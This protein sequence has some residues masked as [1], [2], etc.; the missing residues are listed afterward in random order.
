[1]AAPERTEG[2]PI[3]PG[4]SG[5]TRKVTWSATSSPLPVPPACGPARAGG[6]RVT[7][8]GGFCLARGAD[9]YKV[10]L[11]EDCR[12][13]AST[14][15]GEPLAAVA[16]VAM[17]SNMKCSVVLVGVAEGH[18]GVRGRSVQSL[19]LQVLRGTAGIGFA[20]GLW[21]SLR[22]PMAPQGGRG[23]GPGGA[24]GSFWHPLSRLERRSSHADRSLS[25][26]RDASWGTPEK[27]HRNQRRRADD[28][29]GDLQ[30]RPTGSG[31]PGIRAACAVPCP[32]LEGVER[33][34]SDRGDASTGQ[35][36]RSF[37]KRVALHAAE[38]N[39]RIDRGDKDRQSLARWGGDVREPAS[40]AG[41]PA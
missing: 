14:A 12:D 28:R 33:L 27:R 31:G 25:P 15:R 1:M 2:Q 21:A 18:R 39:E 7:G 22:S 8:A 20:P 40:C 32:P 13:A 26:V 29:F 5:P 11:R 30:A 3:T 6:R 35:G 17:T 38:R 37:L 24:S 9:R 36:R 34:R 41:R 16:G 23:A 19:G 4:G 10:R